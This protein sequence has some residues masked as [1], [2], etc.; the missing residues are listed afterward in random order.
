MRALSTI[1]LAAAAPL[2][3]HMV[4]I[5]TGEARLA[6]RR[7]HYELRMP[8]YEVA[9]V[10]DPGNLLLGYIRF[11]G[12][13]L[14]QKNCRA[15]PDTYVCTA[16]YEFDAEPDRLKVECKFYTVT[17]PNHVH[18][19]RASFG[20][21]SDQ[22]VFDLSFPRGEIRFRPPSA[23]ETAIS[24]IGGGMMNAIG[25]AAQLLFLASLVL[26]ARSRRELVQLAAMFFLGQVLSGTL[27]PTLKWQPA[28]RF[29]EA[30][31]ALTIAYLAVEILMLPEAGKRWAVLGVLGL[32]HGLGLALFVRSAEYSPAYV[33]AGVALG[34]L[35]VIAGLAWLFD[36][37]RRAAPP[38][39]LVR[40][41]AS[42]L[43]AVGLIWFFVRLRS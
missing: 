41:C 23:W 40:I 30:A 28:P 15:E 27:V 6:G 20:D 34:E 29:V 31:A 4:S 19:L 9:H 24:Q 3:A 14:V 26:A 38:L 2:A 12:S 17:V 5:S 16:E 8:L 36:R 39:R 35:P 37:I 11:E 43:F 18:L 42:A 13:R 21:R 33:L 1:C 7:L 25:G 32:F 10:K 22:A